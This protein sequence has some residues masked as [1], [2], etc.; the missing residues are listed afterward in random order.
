MTAS[1]E[2]PTRVAVITGASRGIGAE[3]A[4]LLAMQKRHVVLMARSADALEKVCQDVAQLGG[5]AEKVVCDVSDH[6]ALNDAIEQIAQKHQRLDIMVNNA[7]MTRDNLLLRMEDEEFDSVLHVNLRATFVACR[8]VLRPMMRNRWG[9]IVN[10]SSVAGVV[11]NAGQTNYSAAKSGIIGMTKSIAKE[12]AA[13]GITANVVAPGFIRTAMT[14]D[15]PPQVKDGAKRLT[16]LRRFGEPEEIAAAIA[17]FCS[18][19]AA[20]CTGQVLAVD[21]GMTMT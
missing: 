17:F 9:R 2:Q 21:G 14:H 10:V 3:T 12:M 6:A 1:Q 8:A 4:K 19:Q 16:P 18:D 20:Y 7:G 15:L 5:C 11:G 13:K